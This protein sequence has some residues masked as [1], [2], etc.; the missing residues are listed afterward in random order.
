MPVLKML[1][2]HSLSGLKNSLRYI[3][4]E[5]TPDRD[6]NLISPPLVHNIRAE[7]NDMNAVIE[8][9]TTN[10]AYRIATSNRVY[11]Y[12]SILSLSELDFENATPEVLEQITKH[13]LKLRGDV[14]AFSVA[15]YDSNPH[16]HILESATF[17][18]E[19]KSS[20]LR[21]QEMHQLKVDLESYIQDQFPELKH[22]KVQHGKGM[23][24]LSHKEQQANN[25]LLAKGKTLNKEE[26]QDIVLYCFEQ[27]QS[28]Q[29]FIQMLNENKLLHYERNQDGVPTGVIDIATNRKY[30]FKRFGITQQEIL[31]LAQREQ[32]LEDQR[33]REQQ[34][35]SKQK[36]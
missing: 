16:I 12:H 35:T 19:N 29:H 8:E 33:Q 32:E 24:Y 2:R 30:R 22:S 3:L 10:E 5:N 18:R 11:F 25:K 13:Y 26:V 7:V 23:P 15:H 17:Y 34:N 31:K 20:T 21:K 36:R 1:G 9:F 14:L 27:A 6:D 28:Q 4:R